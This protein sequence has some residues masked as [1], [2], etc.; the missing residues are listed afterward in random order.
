MSSVVTFEE[1]EK[2]YNFIFDT[3]VVDCE[4]GFYYILIDKPSILN[5][6]NTIIIENDFPVIDHKLYIDSILK[7]KGFMCI[8]VEKLD[9]DSTFPCKDFFWETWQR[10]K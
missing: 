10:K 7:S 4:G 8:F 9:S 5:N 1:L 3:L 2:K 6:I